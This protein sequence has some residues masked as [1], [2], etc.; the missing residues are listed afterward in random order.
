M[1]KEEHT[2]ALLEDHAAGRMGNDELHEGLKGSIFYSSTEEAINLYSA[3]VQ[4]I[5]FSSLR[6]EIE[7]ICKE[8]KPN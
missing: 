6:K 1:R 4:A 7:Q 8:E 2:I 3:A 5:E